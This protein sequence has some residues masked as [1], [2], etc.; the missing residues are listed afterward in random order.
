M[1]IYLYF[2]SIIALFYSFGQA[3]MG[4]LSVNHYPQL[5]TMQ[6]G[7]GGQQLSTINNNFREQESKQRVWNCH[8][9]LLV[10][11][12]DKGRYLVRRRPVTS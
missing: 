12:S 9:L 8:T 5:T 11:M 6:K 7:K 2:F 4:R 10:D 3:T 1:Q